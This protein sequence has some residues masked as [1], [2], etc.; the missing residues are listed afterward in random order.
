MKDAKY[1][2]PRGL[3]LDVII[4][5]SDQTYPKQVQHFTVWRKTYYDLYLVVFSYL[6]LTGPSIAIEK[7]AT[8]FDDDLVK[9]YFN[10]LKDIPTGDGITQPIKDVTVSF[11]KYSFP[12]KI[13]ETKVYEP[14]EFVFDIVSEDWVRNKLIKL[15]QLYETEV[16]K[17]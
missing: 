1:L 12:N 7:Y 17:T 16:G 6:S 3:A 15:D 10:R 14:T 4:E 2:F 5:Y 11:I 13:L 9:D 8:I